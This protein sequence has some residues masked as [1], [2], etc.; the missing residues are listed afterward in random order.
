MR[1]KTVA[2]ILIIIGLTI[3]G[4]SL[5]NR[6]QMRKAK[7][8]QSNV[9]NGIANFGSN[10]AITNINFLNDFQNKSVDWKKISEMTAEKKAQLL[11]E[12][13]QGIYINVPIL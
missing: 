8:L 12:I 2:I 4:I 7:Q 10:F 1:N 5:Y 3:I 9:G 13:N 11:N 6:Y